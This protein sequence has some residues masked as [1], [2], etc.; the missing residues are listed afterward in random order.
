M[1]I[2]KKLIYQSTII[3]NLSPFYPLFYKSYNTSAGNH[4]HSN[5]EETLN[6]MK[7]DIKNIDFDIALISCGGYG[8]L[9]GDFIKELGKGAIYVGGGLQLQ[10]GVMGKRWEHNEMFLQSQKWIRPSKDELPP[11]PERIEG[12]C[13]S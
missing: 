3:Y 4:I 8:L 2:Q 7:E 1:H 5:W 9:L 12:G 11:H 10:F 6:I 13:Y